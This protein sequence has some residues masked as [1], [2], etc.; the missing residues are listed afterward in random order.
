MEDKYQ[1]MMDEEN[2]RLNER[3][4]KIERHHDRVR[5]NLL[6]VAPII[7]GVTIYFCYILTRW[8]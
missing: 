1:K 8:V 2:E 3:I 6:S 5:L 4:A 7:I